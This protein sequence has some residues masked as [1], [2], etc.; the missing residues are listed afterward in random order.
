M[1]GSLTISISGTPLR[2]RSIA[3]V[4]AGT[5]ETFVQALA[6]VFFHVQRG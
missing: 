4:S 2:F 6:R 5:D 3:V 1:S